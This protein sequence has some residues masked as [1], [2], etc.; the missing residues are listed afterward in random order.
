MNMKQVQTRKKEADQ[1]YERGE[2]I[3][4]DQD[5]DSEFGL[6]ASAMDSPQE[7]TGWNKFTH[8]NVHMHSLNKVQ[9]ASFQDWVNSH[10]CSHYTCTWKYDGL[11]IALYYEN[12]EFIRAVTRGDGKVGDDITANV[13]K[14]QNLPLTLPDDWSS[15]QVVIKAEIVMRYSS[16]S[17]YL[18]ETSDSKPYANT[19]NGAAGAAKSHDGRNCKYLTIIPYEI[20]DGT[21]RGEPYMMS[22]L[23]IAFDYTPDFYVYRTYHE[24]EEKYYELNKTRTTIDFAV[25]GMVVCVSDPELKT[26]YDSQGMPEFKVALKFPPLMK[27]STIIK[28]EWSMGR[29]LTLT[30]VAIIEPIDLGVN[31]QR[32]SLANVDNVINMKINPGDRVLVSRRN[33]VIPYIEKNL[34]PRPRPAIIILE[35]PICNGSAKIIG[36]FLKCVNPSCPALE[37]G[38]TEKWISEIKK[39]FK[40]KGLGPEGIEAIYDSGLI[41]STPELYT[42]NPDELAACLSNTNN[43]KAENML[44]FQNHKEIPLHVFLAGLNIS[45]LGKSIWNIVIDAGFNTLDKLTTMQ[46]FMIMHLDNIGAERADLMVKGL[47]AK[48]DLISSFASVGVKPI[49]AKPAP[50]VE[51]K[52]KG[53][54]FC[55]TGVLS[56]PRGVIED[57]I[58][59]HGGTIKSGVSK[60]L[61]YLVA[62]ANVGA[63]KTT[64]AQKYGTAVI[65]EHTLVAMLES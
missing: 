3:M 29:S 61:D 42:L 11:A 1:A 25:D 63:T 16:Y 24:L 20:V 28:I 43:K 18:Q 60:G 21:P 56:K 10:P 51:G 23:T 12:R 45:G 57:T 7:D 26:K 2:P 44:E 58:R 50:I 53:K 41:A 31:V 59:D 48:A 32:V 52:L 22:S 54:S 34:N 64:K 17:L 4:T 5:Y 14:M 40:T 37:I 6:N 9:F 30:P 13:R 8:I 15:D 19:R 27:E 36:K 62:G 35:C 49:C 65:D 55:I 39:H 47:V 46:A 33:D 38:N